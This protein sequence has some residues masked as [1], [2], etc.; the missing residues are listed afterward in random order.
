MKSL[1][2]CNIF[3]DMT[4]VSA[5]I[6]SFDTNHQTTLNF[7]DGYIGNDTI[8]TLFEH[9]EFPNLQQPALGYSVN[10]KMIVPMKNMITS[11]KSL[12]HIQVQVLVSNINS[13]TNY[14]NGSLIEDSVDNITDQLINVE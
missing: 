6:T 10:L 2:I 3:Y 9:S 14:S 1:K 8:A 12:H 5:N 4:L 7:L 13:E 11:S